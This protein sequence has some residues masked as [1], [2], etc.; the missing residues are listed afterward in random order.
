MKFV[1][2]LFAIAMLCSCYNEKDIVPT[3]GAE[4]MY[5]LPQ[6]GNA[7][8]DP[9]IV[10]WFEKYGFY[11]VYD[12][13]PEDVYWA[14][15]NWEGFTGVPGLSDGSLE[16][17]KGDPKYIGPL[18]EMFKTFFLKY[19]T[20]DQLAC[21][22]LK[23]F[24]C[25]KLDSRGWDGNVPAEETTRLWFYQGYDYFALNGASKEESE[26]F[27][28]GD[29]TEFMRNINRAFIR[30]LLGQEK[31]VVPE[32]FSKV[33][34]YTVYT[35][36]G[37]FPCY[38]DEYP[39]PW[40]NSDCFTQGY[41]NIQTAK[42]GLT[43][44]QMQYYDFIYYVDL[45]MSYSLAELEEGEGQWAENWGEKFNQPYMNYLGL[46]NPVYELTKIRQKYDIVVDYIR[47]ILGDDYDR[48]QYPE[49]FVEVE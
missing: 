31:L 27:D 8:Y 24:L 41:L 30:I 47:D 2:L 15:R 42:A 10:G 26:N 46:L 32:E 1:Y 49:R 38:P 23:V 48:I 29:K 14:D 28:D 7:D 11:V 6:G 43:K 3:E 18:L 20:E 17:T 33:S 4:K 44:E 22:P 19:Y 36:N 45:V 9:D 5:T 39:K 12:F 25:S 21:M 13:D 35:G 34:N 37:I 16:V 40:Y